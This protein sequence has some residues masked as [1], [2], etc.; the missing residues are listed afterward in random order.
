MVIDGHAHACGS[1]LTSM[2]ITSYLDDHGVDCV[3]L[4]PG[5]LN[6]RKTYSLKDRTASDPGKDTVNSLKYLIRIVVTLSGAAKQIPVGNEYVFGLKRE[7]PRVRQFFWISRESIEEIAKQYERMK[8]DGVKIHQCWIEKKIDT[9]WFEEL[10]CFLVDRDIPLFI[11]LGSY[12]EIP[13]IINVQGRHV[14]LK[15]IIG[16]CFGIERFIESR[17]SLSD[18]VHFDISNNYFVSRERLIEGIRKLGAHRFLLGS[19]TPYGRDSL[20]LTMERVDSLPVGQAVKDAILGLN[21]KRLLWSGDDRSLSGTDV[22]ESR[23]G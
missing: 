17:E 19:D 11:H 13:R 15:L 6:S 14:N 16:H 22:K 7:N 10:V 4:A 1:Y 3:V 21:M 2:Q 5:Q 20:K 18:N 8:F 9:A 12:G 23:E